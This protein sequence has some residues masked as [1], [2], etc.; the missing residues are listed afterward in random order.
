MKVSR[1]WLLA[2]FFL[3]SCS[4]NA[5]APANQKLEYF[6]LRGYFEQEATR[7]SA[8]NT[9]VDKTVSK[10]DDE[11]H[12]KLKI[13]NWLNEFDLFITSDINKPAWKKSYRTSRDR[14]SG[15][16]TYTAIDSTLHTRFIKVI[17]NPFSGAVK[18]IEISNKTSNLLF[19]STEILTY[20]PDSLYSI[21]KKQE[22]LLLG[23][24][25]Y[26]ITGLMVK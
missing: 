6:N 13:S 24:N 2:F 20:C 21:E 5:P 1:L 12:K 10:N 23:K 22:V 3:V 25:K 7:L 4:G 9:L 8:G 19:K 17:L 16:T 26:S 11:E 14:D 15:T 18:R